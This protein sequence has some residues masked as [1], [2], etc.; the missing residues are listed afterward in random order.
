MKYNVTF[1]CGHEGVVDLK[2]DAIGE[3]RLK[4]FEEHGKCP[5]CNNPSQQSSFNLPSLRGS[6]KQI[7]WASSIRENFFRK[8]EMDLRAEEAKAHGFLK[9]QSNLTLAKREVEILRAYFVPKIEAKFWIDIRNDFDGAIAK[10]LA[11][12]GA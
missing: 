4:W 5:A 12:E 6:V 9:G 11:S 1:S 3:G 2:G 10:V 8:M 7:A